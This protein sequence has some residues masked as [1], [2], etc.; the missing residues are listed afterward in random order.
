MHIVGIFTCQRDIYRNWCLP[1]GEYTIRVIERVL[2]VLTLSLL[3]AAQGVAASKDVLAELFDRIGCFFAR[4]EIYTNV[5]PTTAMTG[6]ITDIMVEVLKIFRIATQ[7]PKR[8]STSKFPIDC[9]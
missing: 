3:Q 7:E 8:G 6:I 5:T 9:A 4:L 1:F 2:Q